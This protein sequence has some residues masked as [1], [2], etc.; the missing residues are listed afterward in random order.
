[1]DFTEVIN[2]RRSHRKFTDEHIPEDVLKRIMDAT[3]KAP[4]WSNK[5]GVRYI[6]V[7]DK[8]LLAKFENSGQKWLAK[9]PMVIIVFIS[10]KD[11]GTNSNGLEYFPVD[12]AIA[13][14]QLILAATNEGLGTCWIGWFEEK[15]VKEIVNLPEKARI[16][17]MTPLGYSKY[18]PR[19]IER[20][21]MEKTVYR[22]V[23]SKK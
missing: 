18:T 7:D 3:L 21:S 20:Q 9:A 17:G 2:T 23:Y 14:Q 11:S 1:M 4:S 8:E 19:D 5:Q 13:L 12:A 15:V 22:N 10:P 16:I 6:I